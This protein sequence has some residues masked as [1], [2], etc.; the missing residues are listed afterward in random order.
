MT[1]TAQFL[2]HKKLEGKVAII[3]GGASGI[4]EATAHLFAE[5]GA[6]AIVI[7]DIQDTLGQKVAKSIG[8]GRCTYM[9][10]DVTNED[11]VKALIDSTVETFDASDRIFAINTR[12]M[13]AC[14]KHA[15]RA[16]VEGGVKGGSI[17]CTGSLAG[18]VGLEQFI[19][20]VM[21]K[22]AV[23]GL[24]KSASKGL[25]Q[26]GIRVNCV[27]PGG[28]VTP[29]TCKVMKL[30]LEECENYFEGFMGLKGFGATKAKD[31]ADAVLFL[32]CQDSQFITGH[33]LVVDGGM[34]QLL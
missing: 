21:S 29:L 1:G 20:Y 26:Y 13:A 24:V 15:A 2:Q 16:M 25:G 9:H 30:S 27:S 17:V 11:Q 4:G 8:D 7:A 12:G 34:K 19:D 3:T 33:D 5:H 32:A 23:V 22:H 18:S 31:I 14:V 10:C 28:V 6:R